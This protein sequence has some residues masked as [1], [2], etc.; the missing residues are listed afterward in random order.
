MKTIF[1]YAAVTERI[2]ELEGEAISAMA[3]EY[4]LRDFMDDAAVTEYEALI[5]RRDALEHTDLLPA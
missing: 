4:D 2:T 5:A 3:S 1:D